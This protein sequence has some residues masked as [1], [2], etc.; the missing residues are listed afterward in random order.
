VV[1]EKILESPLDCKEIKPVNPDSGKDWRQEEKGTTEDEMV[2]WHHPLNGHEFE[3]VLR[4]G[5][6]QGSLAC[7]SPWDC[8]ESDRTE[9]L[10]WTEGTQASWVRLPIPAS[11][12]FSLLYDRGW[13][14]WTPDPAHVSVHLPV[15]VSSSFNLFMPCSP[16]ITVRVTAMSVL[17]GD[18]DGPGKSGLCN[19]WISSKHSTV[20]CTCSLWL[21]FLDHSEVGLKGLAEDAQE[22]NKDN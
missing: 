12:P 15:W 21:L 17:R 5:D 11:C 6:G 18:C 22:T 8:K 4:V 2:G 9:W 7:Y 20:I 14:L 10:Y 16:S 3:Q 13:H 1:L 19:W